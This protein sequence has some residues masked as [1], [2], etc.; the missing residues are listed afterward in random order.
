MLIKDFRKMK[1]IKGFIF[2][3]ISIYVSMYSISIQCSA[4][5]VGGYFKIID[6]EIING[7]YYITI[8]SE[9]PISIKMQ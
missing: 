6:K 7:N 4:L 8:S 9:E 3:V 2:L 1:W 5:Q